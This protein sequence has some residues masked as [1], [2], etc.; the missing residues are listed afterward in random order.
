MKERNLIIAAI[1]VLALAAAA[2]AAACYYAGIDSDGGSRVDFIGSNGAVTSVYVEVADT[3]AELQQGLMYRTSLGENNGMLFIFGR[4]GPESF[5]MENTPLPLDMVFINSGM[6]IVDI[7]HNATP[8][9]TSAFTS[10]ESCRYVVEVN[11][12]FCERHGIGI[13]DKTRIY[14]NTGSPTSSAVPA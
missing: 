1:A 6:E 2:S 12:G 9:S 10:R 11:G 3:P 14:V 8:N 7:N 13:G 5:W 4:D